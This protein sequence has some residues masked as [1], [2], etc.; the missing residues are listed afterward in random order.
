M[1]TS[2]VIYFNCEDDATTKPNWPTEGQV[3]TG[4]N[5]VV[6]WHNL[7]FSEV[8]MTALFKNEDGEVRLVRD[9][10]VYT[11]TIVIDCEPFVNF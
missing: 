5:C 10:Q 8:R 6:F 2:G 3:I 7:E 4:L 11:D 1:Q 9:T